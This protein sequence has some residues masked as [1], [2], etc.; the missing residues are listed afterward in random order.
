[1]AVGFWGGWVG[2]WVDLDKV[3]FDGKNEREM[4]D[5]KNIEYKLI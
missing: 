3:G 2:G 1:M 4:W 5:G